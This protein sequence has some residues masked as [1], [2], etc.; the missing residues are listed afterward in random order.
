[1]GEAGDRSSKTEDQEPRKPLR[2]WPGVVIVVVLWLARFGVPVVEPEAMIL[3]VLAVPLGGL[4]IVVWWLFFSRARRGER[5]GALGLTIVGLVA[6]PL[7]LHESIATGMEGLMF[8]IYVTP[9]L[10]LAFVGWA[11]GTRFL[12]GSARG[13]TM[14][15][16]M[17]LAC[18]GW[19][20]VRTGGFT[21]DLD[22]D[23]AWRWSPTPEEQ[24]LA[25]G[26]EDPLERLSV[27]EAAVDGANWPGFRGPGR[28]GV[29][30]GVRID[31]DW[32]ASPPVELWRRAVGPGWSSFA[33][34]AGRFYTQE[35]RGDDEVVSC[36]QL[37]TG[38]LVWRHRN[39][40]RFWESN[41]GAGPRGTPTYH[42]GRIY[43]LG[44]TG[45][46]NVLDAED[47]RVVW[48]R[49]AAT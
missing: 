33:V 24:L 19:A 35:Q 11:L 44:A 40:A 14:A 7:L 28:D 48:S 1:M 6:T 9:V 46:L 27:E 37:S 38:T 45:I 34:H 2:L 42:E 32:V 25:R 31:P 10:S 13:W 8:P 36:H 41:A 4:A 5:W 49:N 21:G 29:V 43:T 20:L 22:H 26:D 30:E 47:G 12:R 16:T 18:A 3:G 39:A 15:G 23:F 17:I